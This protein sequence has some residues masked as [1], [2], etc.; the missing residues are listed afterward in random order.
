MSVV[1]LWLLIVIDMC[2]FL[3]IDRKIQ[4]KV[5]YA[6]KVNYYYLVLSNAGLDQLLKMNYIYFFDW[7]ENC[8][9]NDDKWHIKNI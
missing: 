8:E 7:F 6:A 3:R 1:F 9:R 2:Y 4:I 5:G